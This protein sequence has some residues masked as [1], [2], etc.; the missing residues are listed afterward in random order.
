MS[1]VS[2]ALN[3]A[4]D[5]LEAN[6]DKHIATQ[7]TERPGANPFDPR[8]QCFC[9]YGRFLKELGTEGEKLWATE[10]VFATVQRRYDIDFVD[11]YQRNDRASRSCPDGLEQG[12]P[13]VIPY[14]RELARARV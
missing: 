12:N 7:L 1:L 13:V 4:A 8:A 14:L 2:E 10:D 9:A 5:W 11:V 3:R 6:P